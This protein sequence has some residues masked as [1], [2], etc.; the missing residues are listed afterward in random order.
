MGLLQ[1][2]LTYGGQSVKLEIQGHRQTAAMGVFF[3]CC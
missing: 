2:L 1:Y 3:Q